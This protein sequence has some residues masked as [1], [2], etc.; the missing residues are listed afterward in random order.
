LRRD[1]IARLRKR[2]DWQNAK[3]RQSERVATPK[4]PKSP[5]QSPTHGVFLGANHGIFMPLPMRQ[6]FETYWHFSSLRVLT[7]AASAAGT[8]EIQAECNCPL[9]E[10]LK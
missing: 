6:A 7:L 8:V 3:K 4:N 9:N 1:Q 5:S 2:L 10:D